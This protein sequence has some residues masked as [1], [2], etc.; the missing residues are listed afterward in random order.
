[1][2]ATPEPWNEAWPAAGLE[3][4]PACPVCATAGRTVW[5]P[6]L[7]DNTYHCAR[8]RWALWRCTGCEAGYLD[9]RPDRKTIHQAYDSY[10]THTDLAAAESP[11]PSRLQRLRQLLNN[12]YTRKRFGSKQ[13]PALSLG[14]FA[15]VVFPPL[16]AR[17]DRE[18]RHLPQ[19]PNGPGTLLDLGCGDGA[20]LALARACG[21]TVRGL[22]PDPK[23]A[24]V[25]SARGFEVVE[26]GLERLADRHKDYDVITLSHVIEHVHDPVATLRDCLRLLRPG[27]Q[28]WL[29]TPNANS[30]SHR[31]FGSDWRGLEAP[32]HLLLFTQSAL[33]KAL[34]D[35]GFVNIKTQPRPSPRLWMF[36]HSLAMRDGR[37]SEDVRPIP[38]MWR[39]RALVG[40]LREVFDKRYREHLTVTA[41]KGV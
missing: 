5:H 15:V 29:E 28:L 25:A 39:W 1:M 9:P 11:P 13:L 37:H 7:V 2:S 21:W 23:A 41:Q 24:Q 26:G 10:Y 38:A 18:F 8:G 4:V 19:L 16:R 14:F 32:R 6:A 22:E 30:L 3:S 12:G 36:Q 40:D 34:R 35:A 17:A 31:Y 33:F 27:G 20:F